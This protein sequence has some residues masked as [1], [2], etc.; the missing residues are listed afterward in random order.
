MKLQLH[1]SRIVSG[2]DMGHTM[3]RSFTLIELLIVIAI[4]A[5]LVAI[6]LPA[7]NKARGRAQRIDCVNNLRQIGAALSMYGGDHK[8]YPPS[9]WSSAGYTRYYQRWYHRLRPYLG[10][11]DYPDDWT[12][13]RKLSRF[14]ALFCKSTDMFYNTNNESDTTSYAMNA[15]ARL[16]EY[17]QLRPAVTYVSN[18]TTT[19][20]YAI[21]PES[22]AN[23]SVSRII[24]IG[25]LGRTE[26]ATSGATRPMIINGQYLLGKDYWPSMDTLSA[27]RRHHGINL[28]MLDGHVS[29]LS[30][31][32]P[33]AKLSHNLY[34]F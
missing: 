20:P 6:L 10:S 4:I 3:R 26:G 11:N 2:K 7:I 5:I 19:S 27:T 14:G 34:L 24:F 12:N 28:L 22:R 25:E 17:N 32:A 29:F 8:Y 18:P 1:S 23:V 30:A 9:D 31:V 21:K 15:F 16:V 33:Q 13:S